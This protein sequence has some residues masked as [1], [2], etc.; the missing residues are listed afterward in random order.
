M[1]RISI[2]YP[3]NKQERYRDLERKNP[4]NDAA[5]RGRQPSEEGGEKTSRG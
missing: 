2:L 1:K 3:K 4:S 5:L